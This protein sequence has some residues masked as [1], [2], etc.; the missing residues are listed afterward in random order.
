MPIKVEY[1]TAYYG[2]YFVSGDGEEP[3]E[4]DC[5]LDVSGERYPEEEEFVHENHPYDWGTPAPGETM[6]P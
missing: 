6:H 1:D 4:A 2:N 5:L 3:G